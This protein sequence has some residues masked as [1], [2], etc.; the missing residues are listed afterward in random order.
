MNTLVNAD[1]IERIKNLEE[2][3]CIGVC[4]ATATF[5]LADPTKFQIN[6]Y[7]GDLFMIFEKVKKGK[8]WW[9]VRKCGINNSLERKLQL[10][11]SKLPS[12]Y[13][14]LRQLQIEQQRR[15]KKLIPR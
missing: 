4:V 12:T 14:E 10:T 7:R 9:I 2:N 13:T 3:T 5:Q 15:A 11:S 8:K 1:K 6:F